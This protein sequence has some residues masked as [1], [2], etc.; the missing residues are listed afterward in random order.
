MKTLFIYNPNAGM[1]Q[2]KNYLYDILNVFSKANYDLTV[3][4]TKATQEAIKHVR[5]NCDRFDLIICSG[6]DG[7]LN[8]V[9]NGMMASKREILPL[10]GYIPAGSTND[11]ANSLKLPNDMVKAAKLIT[12]GSPY[13]YDIGKFNSRYFVYVAAFGAFSEVSYATPQDMKNAIGHLAYIVEGIKSLA[14]IKSY[15]VKFKTEELS[16]EGNFIYGMISNTYSVGGIYKLDKKSVKFD[17]GQFEVLLIREPKDPIEL[18]EISGFILGNRKHTDMVISFKTSHIK[19]E[20]DDNV[21]W[22]LD[23]EY[24]GNPNKI[25]ISVI[26]NAIQIINR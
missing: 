9:V 23:G 21:P 6:G 1:M 17:D 11:F 20:T 19:I 18:G 13:K 15:K 8:E 5:K 2:I 26:N 16:V 25:N 10:L 24:G 3:L 14:N 7:T 4:P 22:T 12:I